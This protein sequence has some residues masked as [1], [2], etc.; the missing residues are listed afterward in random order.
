MFFLPGSP[1]DLIYRDYAK[2]L[3]HTTE[4]A[5]PARVSLAELAERYDGIFLDSYGVLN[6]AGEALPLAA[7]GVAWLKRQGKIVR[8]LTNNSALSEEENRKHLNHIGIPLEAGDVFCSGSLLAD[9]VKTHDLQ[10]P[11]FFLGLPG[12]R[13]Y[14]TEAGLEETQDPA[15]ARVVV[16]ASTRGY[17]MRRIGVALQAL[18]GGDVPLV[19]LNP[20]AVA[21][22]EGGKMFR[23]SGVT[24][25]SLQART[26][27]SLHLLGKPFPQ[28]YAM[29]L[30]RTGLDAKRCVMI[31]DTLAT[32]IL[33]ART[34]GFGAALILTGVTPD[35]TALAQARDQRIWPD[36]LLPDLSAPA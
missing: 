3:G 7:E 21:P 17:R 19:V 18:R 10:G 4:V 29:A 12:A 1:E 6:R 14:L 35:A 9:C 32:D 30:A 28:M 2:L 5:S 34:A 22:R 11:A 16:L 20:D 15:Q 13:S 23:V 36:F 24:A 27:C 26:G 25:R 31:G 33:G 8:V